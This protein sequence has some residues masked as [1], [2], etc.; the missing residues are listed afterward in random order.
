[1]NT[2]SPWKADF[3]ALARAVRGQPLAFLDT[4]ASAQ[5][6]QVVLDTMAE[7]LGGAYANIHRGL[8]YNS[9]L[10]TAAYEDARGTV[11]RFVNADPHGTIFVRNAT[12]AINLVAAT[13]GRQNLTAKSTVL[14]TE[15]EHHANIVPWQLLQE[16]IGFTIIVAPVNDA[17]EVTPEAIDKLLS[18]HDV[19]ICCITQK[20]NVLGTRTQLSQ[21]IPALKN[22]G[23]MVLVDGAQAV[24]HGPVNLKTL[25]A[26]FYVFSGHK[27]YGPTGVGV[28]CAAPELLN[29]LPPYMGGGDMIETVSFSK[30]TYARS[31]ARFEAGTPAIAEAIGLAAACDYLSAIGWEK[32]VAHEHA[33]AEQLD[34]AL[35]G[36]KGLQ[37]YGSAGL[38]N[39]IASF[40]LTGCQASDVATILDQH[41]V[42]VRSGHHCAMPLHARLGTAASVRASLGLY[43]DSTDIAQLVE[44]LHKA[45][46]L[47]S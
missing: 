25:G 12:E 39:G 4:G 30:T 8:Y 34:S 2:I 21:I 20:S 42:A 17:G 36:I 15:L 14:L 43:N 19:S 35:A 6:P 18:E 10:T 37:R 41:G 40:N 26:D 38:G 3:P 9:Q 11:A 13:W 31:P 5:K 24:V 46:K 28:L 44:G 23:A 32:I 16:Q 29:S 1:M 45:Q 7:V 33:L 27:L 22:A 47:L